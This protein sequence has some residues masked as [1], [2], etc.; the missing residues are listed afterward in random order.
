MKKTLKYVPER[1]MD[2]GQTKTYASRINKGIATIVQTI[3]NRI[4]IKG[5]N[6]IHPEKEMLIR[7]DEMT[8]WDRVKNGHLT[9]TQIKNLTHAC[10]HGLIEG[11]DSVGNY[12]LTPKG[13]KFLR[14]FAVPFVFIIDKRTHKPIETLKDS[15]GNEIMGTIHELR[16]M[17][18]PEWAGINYTV[19]EGRVIPN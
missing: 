18:E 1:C 5:I 19:E 13:I 10:H 6:A 3:A 9:H 11:L 12:G 14:G 15:D 4:G 17:N 7:K 8:R 16:N 2:C